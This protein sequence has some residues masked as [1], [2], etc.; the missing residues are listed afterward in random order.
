MDKENNTDYSTILNPDGDSHLHVSVGI[1]NQN[2][3][4]NMYVHIEGH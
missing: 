3:P 1:V 4:F 2:V